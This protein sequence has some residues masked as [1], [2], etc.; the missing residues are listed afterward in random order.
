MMGAFI[1]TTFLGA[2][3][4]VYTLFDTQLAFELST[5]ASS[6]EKS[7]IKSATGAG[8]RPRARSASAAGAAPAAGPAGAPWTGARRG[9]P[10]RVH[11]LMPP[12]KRS[13]AHSPLSANAV[14]II[15]APWSGK[16]EMRGEIRDEIRAFGGSCIGRR[17]E[18]EMDTGGGSPGE[19]PEMYD[20]P[21]RLEA[22]EALSPGRATSLHA[23]TLATTPQHQRALSDHQ[24][25][26]T[27]TARGAS[28]GA[29]RQA[30]SSVPAFVQ[31]V[32]TY[33]TPRSIRS[34][35]ASPLP[36]PEWW[37]RPHLKQ[38]WNNSTFI[39]RSEHEKRDS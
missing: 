38:P 35:A 12:T 18:G 26:A 34:K 37:E 22:L 4:P 7:A 30:S 28:G 5:P 20:F 8:T 33:L 15:G 6:A 3:V 11:Q 32:N 23:T 14:Q 19:R 16:G 2:I 29:S 10:A 36:S 21:R 24:S 17:I 13:G 9:D 25:F 1:E 27:G 39:E 31:A